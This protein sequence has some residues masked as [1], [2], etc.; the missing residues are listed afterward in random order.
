VISAAA[1]VAAVFECRHRA[2]GLR[3]SK[4]AG[5]REFDAML[6]DFKMIGLRT[7]QRGGLTA[8]LERTI[9]LTSTASLP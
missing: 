7:Q 9:I 4:A 1:V 3:M 5:R 6:L 8:E 2:G